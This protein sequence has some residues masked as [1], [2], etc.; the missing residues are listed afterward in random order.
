MSRIAW[1]NGA[2]CAAAITFDGSND[3]ISLGDGT[4]HPEL[5]LTTFT[6]EALFRRS[7][8]GA[9]ATVASGRT[10]M[11][12]VAKGRELG[13]GTGIDINYTLA[14]EGNFLIATYEDATGYWI[15]SYGK[16]GVSSGPEEGPTSN[17]NDDI[18]MATGVF[19]T[20]PEGT[21]M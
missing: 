4:T 8:T 12:I 6:V 3:R 15:G 20:Y 18:F 9:L 14:I 2:R 5:Q 16:D 21:Q 13:D 1:P 10:A 17:F 11:P 19:V 7:G